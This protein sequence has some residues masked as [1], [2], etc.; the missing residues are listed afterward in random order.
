MGL[1]SMGR[2]HLANA[3]ADE[4][5]E[6]TAVCDRDAALV[7]RVAAEHGVRCFH[8]FD[9]MIASGVCEAVLIATP[10]ARHVVFAQPALEAGVH[11]LL[12]KPVAVSV[13]GARRLNRAYATARQRHPNLVFSAMFQQR[14]MPIWQ[15]LKALVDAGELGVLSRATWVVTDWIRSNAYY[16]AAGWRGTWAGEGGGVLMNQA[17]HNLDLL[18]WLTGLTPAAVTATIGRGKWHPIETE[19]DV[20]A[21]IEFASVDGHPPAVGQF[22]TGT[23]EAPGINRLELVGDRATVLAED[24]K[25]RVRRLRESS[26]HAIATGEPRMRSVAFD[27]KTI[28]F[29]DAT[30]T[31]FADQEP[32][33]QAVLR[34][35]ALAI[36]DGRPPAIEGTDGV[37]SLELANAMLL[38]GFEG[39]R[40]VAMPLGTGNYQRFLEAKIAQA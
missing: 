2:R 9:A 16:A 21:T 4:L 40:R 14:L 32:F 39:G 25:L 29:G 33:R 11:V 10:H 37:K 20:S 31:T 35:F 19:D 27:E 36:R 7:D 26:R 15:R 3:L 30:S 13:E 6:V 28:D 17:P 1:G 38:S 12:E 23:G 5:I 34:D 22:V 18:L 8:E 24:G